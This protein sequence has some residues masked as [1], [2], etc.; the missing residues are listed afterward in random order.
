MGE[1]RRFGARRRGFLDGYRDEIQ[2]VGLYVTHPNKR[3]M[4]GF[5]EGRAAANRDL[6]ERVSGPF[7][8]PYML[9]SDHLLASGAVE[10]ERELE[11]ALRE[12]AYRYQQAAEDHL[13]PVQIEAAALKRQR[14]DL[15]AAIDKHKGQGIG[16][17]RGNE[18]AADRAL[19]REAQQIRA[20][21][22]KR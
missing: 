17:R 14:D 5:E 12:D 19:Y 10:A 4:A 6:A 9:V 18:T 21:G 7:E 1:K 11:K 16:V 8:L 13:N 2:G 15:L 20:E 3:W 22:E